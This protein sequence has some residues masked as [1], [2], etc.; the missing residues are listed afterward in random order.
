MKFKHRS[1][2]IVML[3]FVVGFY[4]TKC[5][6]SYPEVNITKNTV[7]KKSTP[8]KLN[9]LSKDEQNVILNKGTER[10]FTGEYT[11]KFTKGTYV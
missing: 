6:N 7:I 11:D 5:Q 3:L 8:M 10:P 2:I 4:N 9:P 1:L